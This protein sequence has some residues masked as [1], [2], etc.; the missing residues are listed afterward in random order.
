MPLQPV[1]QKNHTGCFIACVAMLLDKSY[2]EAFQLLHPG[3]NSTETYEH[4]FL[5]MSME[6]TANK[7]LQKLGFRSRTSKYRKFRTFQKRVNKH[8]IMIIRWKFDPTRCHCVLFDAEAK[9]FIDPSGGYIVESKYML[10]RLQKQLDSAIIIEQ[11]P[12][13]KP[14][15]DIPRTDDALGLAW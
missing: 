11:L 13:L 14:T 7:L 3:K 4:G 12:E 10:D 5:D 2:E 8:A 1:A 9:A 15:N 6:A